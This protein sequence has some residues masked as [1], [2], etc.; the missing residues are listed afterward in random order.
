MRETGRTFNAIRNMIFGILLKVVQIIIPLLMRTVMIYF[1]GVEYLGLSGLFTSVLQ[2]LN[3]AELGISQAMTFSMYKPVAEN[4][5]EKICQLLNLYKRYYFW[6][7]LVVLVIGVALFPF[8][9]HLISGEVPDDINIYILYVIYLITTVSSYWMFTYRSSLL[10]A[11]QRNDVISKVRLG[12]N[13]LQFALQFVVL[14]LYRNYYLYIV[15]Q[16]LVQIIYQ[17]VLCY[18]VKKVYPEFRPEGEVPK[19]ER[20][21]ITQKVKDLATSKFGAV[22]LNS[23]DTIVISAFL[24]LSV[25]GVYQNY[26]YILTSVIG[27]IAM[28][29]YGATAGIGNSIVMEDREKVYGDFY[30]FSFIIS[31]IVC[32]CTCC[33]LCLYQP[34]MKLWVGEELM[35]DFSAVILFCIYFYIYEF[36]QLFNLYKDAAGLWHKDKFRPLITSLT[37]LLMNVILVQYIGIYGVLLSTVL[38]VLIVGMPWLLHNLFGSLFQRAIGGYLKKLLI[39]VLVTLISCGV[40][41]VCC[42]KILAEGFLA[43]ILRGMIAVAVPVLLYTA[44][45]CKTKEFRKMMG[46]LGRYSKLLIKEK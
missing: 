25:L 22:I 14:I 9:P 33:F 36:N 7:G 31:W 15:I 24:G 13:M 12:T 29:M 18:V 10:E 45:F 27:M 6:I 42:S 26:Y 3:L 46:L 5:R 30:D 41:Y 37:N 2:I 20:A 39:Y 44:L 23:S 34:F 38:S 32:I 8:L 1:I 4:N 11:H 43:L 28:I 19:E 17:I 21:A 40:T 35:L 16:L